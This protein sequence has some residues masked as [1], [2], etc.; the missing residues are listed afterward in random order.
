MTSW[1][2]PGTAELTGPAPVFRQP[3]Q[4][5][6]GAWS[7][8]LRG[9]VQREPV[10]GRIPL[11]LA[12]CVGR[13]WRVGW[14]VCIGECACFGVAGAGVLLHRPSLYSVFGGRYTPS[15]TL[16]GRTPRDQGSE[17]LCAVPQSKGCSAWQAR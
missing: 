13:R 15:S 4:F 11:A 10:L 5:A 14:G 3:E 17:K 16:R 1:G 7:W 2:H 6:A 12:L 8:R 9:G